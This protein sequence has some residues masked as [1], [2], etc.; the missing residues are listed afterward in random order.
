MRRVE[1]TLY[2]EAAPAR[3]WT[4]LT[5]FAVYPQWSPTLR[6]ISGEPVAG[7]RLTVTATAPGGREW[8]FRPLVLAAEPGRVLRWRARLLAPGVLTG[9]HEFALEP[10]GD[11]T[12]LVHSDTFTGVLVPLLARPLAGNGPGMHRQNAALRERVVGRTVR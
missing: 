4:V 1:T 3:V 7:T 8:T 6:R 5:D 10:E 12:R 11:G 2:I 9:V